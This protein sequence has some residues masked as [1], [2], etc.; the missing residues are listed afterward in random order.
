M[1]FTWPDSARSDLRSIDREN[2]LRIL[3]GLT[4]FGGTGKGD[5]KALSKRGKDV[6]VFEL[7][8]IES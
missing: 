5:L 4:E 2:A 1:R 8:T 7:A 6:G 3:Q